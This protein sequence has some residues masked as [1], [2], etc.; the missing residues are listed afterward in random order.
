MAFSGGLVPDIFPQEG[1]PRRE[2]AGD[3]ASQRPGRGA[4]GPLGCR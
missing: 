1:N 4:R 2:V 3:G